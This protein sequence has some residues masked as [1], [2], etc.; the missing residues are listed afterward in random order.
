MHA[1]PFGDIDSAGATIA[2][3]ALCH[4]HVRACFTLFRDCALV[5]HKMSESLALL[6]VHRTDSMNATGCE[7][8]LIE[9]VRRSSTKEYRCLLLRID[10]RNIAHRILVNPCSS[11][12]D[13][14]S[15]DIRSARVGTVN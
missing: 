8:L 11:S 9:Q 1:L 4:S 13:G 14:K 6:D 3:A 10:C 2:F 5:M 12:N 15:Y 7:E